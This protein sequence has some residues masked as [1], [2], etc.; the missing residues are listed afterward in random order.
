MIG[1]NHI[2]T[3]IY[4]RFACQKQNGTTYLHLLELSPEDKGSIIMSKL[5]TGYVHAK[6]QHPYQ[7]WDR[8]GMFRKLIVEEAVLSEV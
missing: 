1:T 7:I 5:R 4:W 2:Q 6:S 8:L 3:T